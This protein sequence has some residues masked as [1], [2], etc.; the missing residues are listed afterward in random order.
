LQLIWLF[1]IE[2]HVSQEM[3]LLTAE[4]IATEDNDSVVKQ[5]DGTLV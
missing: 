4:A 1:E 2:R 3:N 5:P